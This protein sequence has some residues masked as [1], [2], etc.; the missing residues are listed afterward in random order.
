L[1]CAVAPDLRGGV[2]VALCCGGRFCCGG[3]AALRRNSGK[4]TSAK[5]VGNGLFK[6]DFDLF[7]GE[8]FRS[9]NQAFQYRPTLNK[10]LGSGFAFLR[11]LLLNKLFFLI[12]KL[13]NS[14]I[15]FCDSFIK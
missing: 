6:K 14:L 7:I 8:V 2:G 9:V 11:S 3:F 4:Y 5:I 10:P 15:G 13:C 1:P 12:F